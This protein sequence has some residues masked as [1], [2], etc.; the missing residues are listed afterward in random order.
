MMSKTASFERILGVLVL[1][2]GLGGTAYGGPPKSSPSI[3]DSIPAAV[4]FDPDPLLKIHGSDLI[5]DPAG[6]GASVKINKGSLVVSVPGSSEEAL[7]VQLPL[8]SELCT[9]GDTCAISSTTG[10]GTWDLWGLA[11]SQVSNP[12]QFPDGYSSDGAPLCS[13]PEINRMQDMQGNPE[14]GAT[15]HQ[16]CV[17]LGFFLGIAD[18]YFRRGA[19]ER[20]TEPVVDESGNYVSGSTFARVTC[21]AV[22]GSNCVTW[23][24]V[25]GGCDECRYPDPSVLPWDDY[26][27]LW[28]D[29]EMEIKKGAKTTTQTVRAR[30]DYYQLPFRMTVT[31]DLSRTNLCN[32]GNVESCPVP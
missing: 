9:G 10:S 20:P 27:A 29:Q 28:T 6:V 21:T 8:S 24:I 18:V 13:Y 19:G 17:E 16:I 23:E 26:A 32:L 12:G 30:E 31:T 4:F 1:A 7:T 22:S 2:A 25:P 15:P 3:K 14:V 11:T 5:D